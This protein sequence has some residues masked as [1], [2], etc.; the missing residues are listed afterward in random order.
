MDQA[1]FY[2]G[3]RDHLEF[4][5]HLRGVAILSVFFA[6]CLVMSFGI[7][8]LPWNG[9]FPSFRVEPSFIMLLP[10]TY[11]WA[12][13]ALFFVISG[14]CI[15][16]SHIRSGE[17]GFARFFIRRFFR[18]YPPYLLCVLIFFF[19]PPWK[20]VGLRSFLG[21]GQLVS[22]LLLVHNLDDHFF[23]GINSAFWSIAVEVQLY[24]LYPLLLAMV[25]RLGW[26]RTLIGLAALEISLRAVGAAYQVMTGQLSPMWLTLPGLPVAYWLSWSIGAYLADKYMKGERAPFGDQRAWFWAAV[27][28]GS[29]LF[30]PTVTFS[31]LAFSLL[32]AIVISRCLNAAHRPARPAAATG[33]QYLGFVGLVS[34]SFYLI[35]QPIMMLVLRIFDKFHL[36]V[37]LYTWRTFL[38]LV[39]TCPIILLLSW[40]LYV[41]VEKTSVRLGKRVLSLNLGRWQ[42]PVGLQPDDHGQRRAI[43]SPASE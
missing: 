32:S 24:C 17:Q 27:A 19:L 21:V 23:L 14:F 33:A 26:K 39:G 13:V 36:A 31:F 37:G 38:V 35:H 16:L 40:C 8:R 2:R 15:H 34:Y 5:D 12:G 7:F 9:W 43:T 20:S 25:S 28:I 22:H 1:K 30:R 18:I 11:G 42:S 10:C 41:V 3:R 6:H 29:Y 4:L